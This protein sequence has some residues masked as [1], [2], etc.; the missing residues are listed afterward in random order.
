M[1]DADAK[2]QLNIVQQP[3][4]A[5]V[6]G[7]KQT[8]N[9]SRRLVD[10]QPVV[11]IKL[12][13]TSV[14]DN[15]IDHSLSSFFI[16]CSIICIDTGSK[17][18]FFQ[19]QRKSKFFEHSEIDEEVLRGTTAVSAQFYR[20][21][22]YVA[23]AVFDNLSV[24][25][26]G[27]YRLKFDLYEL[28]SFSSTGPKPKIVHWEKC[29]TFSSVFTV[30]TDATFDGLEASPVLNSELK[31]AGCKIRA[32]KNKNITDA[33]SFKIGKKYT[34]DNG[35]LK[36]ILK[37][38]NH[39]GL[40]DDVLNRPNSTIDFAMLQN[41]QPEQPLAPLN[42]NLK[43]YPGMDSSS[44]SSESPI[45]RPQTCLPQL[46]TSMDQFN[47]F[48]AQGLP[49]AYSNLLF[50]NTGDKK[51]ESNSPL[52]KP[53][54]RR[55]LPVSAPLSAQLLWPNLMVSKN[56]NNNAITTPVSSNASA[57][58]SV[59]SSPLISSGQDFYSPLIPSNSAFIGNDSE[60]YTVSNQATT[61]MSMMKNV[62]DFSGT[63]P[64]KVLQPLHHA[65]QPLF[66]FDGLDALF[67]NTG[68]NNNNMNT[69]IGSSNNVPRA[70]NS[71]FEPIPLLWDLP[72]DQ[73]DL[74]CIDLLANSLDI[75]PQRQVQ[76]L[77]YQMNNNGLF[78]ISPTNNSTS[79][80]QQQK[81]QIQLLQEKMQIQQKPHNFLTNELNPNL[82]TDI[83]SELLFK[84]I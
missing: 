32:R 51:L 14:S 67:G 57:S 24:R 36:Y 31:K 16:R 48:P 82:F 13:Q 30:Y 6:A 64:G 38:A 12:N 83:N 23:C 43:F 55:M 56:S 45:K 49:S 21:S 17:E 3:V 74:S 46:M 62:F 9:S 52:E 72:S 34:Y 70:A 20:G 19:K 58:N 54:P 53:Q 33:E 77:Q 71:S 39:F 25:Y 41:F 10:P 81:A 78:G 22:P 35:Q 28:Q 7:R 18:I 8:R 50:P 26:K 27:N 5:R 37:G 29:T 84:N 59:H 4:K 1:V 42:T 80:F 69:N 63:K 75:S 2:Y 47:K 44:L 60:L 73:I 15:I 61:P 11:E 79:Q 66:N 65:K 40:D 68:A 76:N